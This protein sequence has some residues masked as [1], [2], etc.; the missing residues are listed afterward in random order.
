MEVRNLIIGLILGGALGSSITYFV[1]KGKFEKKEDDIR[2]EARKEYK[3]YYERKQAEEDEAKATHVN[4]VPD[5]PI[6][7]KEYKNLAG[8]YDRAEMERPSEEDLI[9][10]TEGVNAVHEALEKSHGERT[11]ILEPEHFGEIT[12]Y[13]CESLTYYVMDKTLVHEDGTVVDDESFLIGDALERY[14]WADSDEDNLPLYVRNYRIAKD[15]EIVKV[16]GEYDPD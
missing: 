2:T 8:L 4:K 13:E 3:E 6:E 15:F 11:K 9:A 1:M 5:K 12:T 16:M 14:N 7:T 10:E